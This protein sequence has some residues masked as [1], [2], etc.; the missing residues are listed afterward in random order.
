MALSLFGRL[1][2]GGALLALLTPAH[3]QQAD[4]DPSWRGDVIVVRGERQDY[5]ADRAGV[6]CV[7]LA[8]DAVGAY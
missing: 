2:G 7:P 8:G 5:G 6:L 3:A 1:L 4:Q